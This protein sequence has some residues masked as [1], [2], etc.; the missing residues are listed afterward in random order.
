M[1]DV[2]DFKKRARDESEISDSPEVKRLREDLLDNLDDDPEFCTS[3]Q[4]LD[5]F[6]KSFE[7]EITASA[8]VEVVVLDSESGDSR[9]DLGYLLGA[10]DDELGIPPPLASPV[11]NE[12][13]RVESDP[14]D[15]GGE[16]WGL[17]SFGEDAFVYNGEFEELDDG[18][19][20]YLD[21]GFGFGRP[22]TLPAQ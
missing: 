3:N 5:S 14:S 17:D 19:F 9:P 1:E 11:L 4:D 18:L 7:E 22:E 2:K 6:M 13:V 15:F 21:L 20:D 10:S 12:L 8:A 16:F